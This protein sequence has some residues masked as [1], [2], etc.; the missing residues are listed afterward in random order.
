MYIKKK[1][2]F[3]P[4]L[5]K[6]RDMSRSVLPST[7]RR[8]A[9]KDLAGVRR[10]HR[11]EVRK[12]LRTFVDPMRVDDLEFHDL[13]DYHR[14]P[15]RATREV[16][17]AR[18]NADKVAPLMR[19]AVGSTRSIRHE[20]RLSHL[21]A[22]LPANL[23]GRHA[24]THLDWMQELN[25]IKKWSI[26]WFSP[27]EARDPNELREAIES[28]MDAGYHRAFNA[29]VKGGVSSEVMGEEPVQACRLLLGLH[30]I[31]SFVAVVMAPA[32]ARQRDQSPALSSCVTALR[33]LGY[34]S[35]LEW[36]P[37]NPS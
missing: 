5:G 29:F 8:A 2:G 33:H 11:R 1:S 16:V 17:F 7:R 30:D 37:V 13:S 23:I 32:S 24:M 34:L 15:T 19:W 26:F 22:I 35:G 21:A 28:V 20:D 14:Y 36:G 10:S 31:E 27:R 9:A 6:R 4:R 12:Q 3:D 25:P 18:R